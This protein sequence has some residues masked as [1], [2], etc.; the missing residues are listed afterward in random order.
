[1][2]NEQMHIGK[3][4]LTGCFQDIGQHSQHLEY[5]NKYASARL[6]F[7]VFLS[8]E[9]SGGILVASKTLVNTVNINNVL[10]NAHRR[11]YPCLFSVNKTLL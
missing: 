3:I 2:N 11:R 8:K 7:Y 4:I 6:F 5:I 9:R 1:M 10:T